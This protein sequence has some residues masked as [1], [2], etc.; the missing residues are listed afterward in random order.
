MDLHAV[1]HLVYKYK[2]PVKVSEINCAQGDMRFRGENIKSSQ[3][4]SLTRN[5]D[6]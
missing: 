3:E 6:L 4:E 1:S 2:M 5:F